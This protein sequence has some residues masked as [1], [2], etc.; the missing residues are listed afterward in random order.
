MQAPSGTQTPFYT[1]HLRAHERNAMNT[2]NTRKR[3]GLS[4]RS[5]VIAAAA[6]AVGAL[7]VT[8]CSSTAS[9]TDTASAAPVASAS[10]DAM[11]PSAESSPIGGNVLPPVMVEPGQTEAA[12]KV[13]DTI[14]FNVPADKLAGTTISTDQ[15]TLL[16]LSQAKQ[17]GDALFN[18]GA[19][20]LAAGTAVV[21]ITGPDNTTSQV[22]ITIAE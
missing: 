6:L 20:A 16:E 10:A 11:Q 3:S 2:S 21:T 8:A 9:S 17:E 4:V 1:S 18:P 22:T 14:V 15:P 5:T 13:G 19:K 7:A 12:A